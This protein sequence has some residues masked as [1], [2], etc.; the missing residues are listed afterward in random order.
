MP[1]TV[2]LTITERNTVSKLFNKGG[3]V[4]NFST[5]RFN[6]FTFECVGIKLCEH[7]RLS[8]GASLEK[9]LVDYPAKKAVLLV[10]ALL[11]Y[12]QSTDDFF[13]VQNV[14][15]VDF[16]NKMIAKYESMGVDIPSAFA[17]SYRELQDTYQEMFALVEKNPT[18]AIGKAKELIESCCK[19]VLEKE[20]IAYSHTDD[21]GDLIKKVIDD[22]KLNPDDIPSDSK[23]I[24]AIKALL[25]NLRAIAS[26]MA[27]IRNEYG[28]GHGKSGS[29]KGLEPRHA[30]L[31][32]HSSITLVDFIWETYLSQKPN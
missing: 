3:Y 25:G 22:L 16:C 20:G 30:R 10:K 17:I 26:S 13:Y 7:Y 9:Y 15:A 24:T 31:A 19:T 27:T 11:E 18:D 14:N 6:D 28:S 23:G 4:L 21:M 32:V 5:D 29:Y 1:D 12:A 2:K 8:K